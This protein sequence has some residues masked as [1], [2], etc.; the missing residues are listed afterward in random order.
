MMN[1]P[2]PKFE[3][4]RRSLLA[5]VQFIDGVTG[6]PVSS[7]VRVVAEGLHILQKPNGQVLMLAADD[8]LDPLTAPIKHVVECYPADL[9]YLPRMAAITLPRKIDGTA[10]SLFNPAKIILY[11][12]TS[13]RCDGNLGGL[14][15]TVKDG[16]N[17]V[18]RGAVVTLKPNG[19]DA[20]AARAVTNAAGEALLI[21]KGAAVVQYSAGTH[22]EIISATLEILVDA[23]PTK[24]VANTHEAIAVARAER[25]LTNPDDLLNDAALVQQSANVSFRAGRIQAWTTP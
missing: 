22:S 8:D 25:F 11:P 16:I 2:A 1:A 3:F 14:L 5:A 15:V 6:V 23:D 21:V 12:S 19:N 10:D 4:E 17:K 7:K 20:L 13:Y 18:V 24:R 9:A